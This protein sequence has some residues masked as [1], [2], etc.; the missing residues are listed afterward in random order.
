[1]LIGFMHIKFARTYTLISLPL[2]LNC[3]KTFICHKKLYVISLPGTMELSLVYS[4]N[5]LL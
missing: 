1:M 4:V 5:L 2:L 3:M